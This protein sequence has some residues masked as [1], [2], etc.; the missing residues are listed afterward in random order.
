MVQMPKHLS[1]ILAPHKVMPDSEPFPCSR[2]MNMFSL[3]LAIHLI[4][5]QLPSKPTPL[6]LQ[7]NADVLNNAA[8]LERDA[9]DWGATQ[10]GVDAALG[11]EVPLQLPEALIAANISIAEEKHK[12]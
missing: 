4:G 10:A 3:A 1:A 9:F 8:A 7:E 12:P 2:L 11:V 6:T 5:R